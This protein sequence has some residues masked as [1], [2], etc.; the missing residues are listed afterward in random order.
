MKLKESGKQM[1]SQLKPDLIVIDEGHHGAAA[2]WKAVEAAAMQSSTQEPA[3]RDLQNM[4]EKS[5]ICAC[6]DLR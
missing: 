3:R 6:S 5:I 4:R 1:L 2:S